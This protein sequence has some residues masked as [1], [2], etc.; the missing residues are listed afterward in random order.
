MI[1]EQLLKDYGGQYKDFQKQE[2]IFK[3]GVRVQYFY[4]IVSGKVKFSSISKEGKEV[5]QN[6]FSNS[7]C[8]GEA[9]LFLEQVAPVNAI[10]LQE[11]KII[12]LSKKNFFKLLNDHPH[13]SFE[14][15]KLFAQRLFYKM[16]LACHLTSIR[17]DERLLALLD[18]LKFSNPVDNV[19]HSF[20]VLITRQQMAD[21]TGLSVETV[22]RTIKSMEK[23]GFVSI[24]DHKIFY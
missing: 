19:G 11:S 24:E 5:I 4:Q 15:N 9:F 2:I 8:F 20:Q 6:L 16:K 10:T 1:P 17:P 3:E 12:F 14:I 13:Y 18:F 7:Q 23:A 21:F 22:I